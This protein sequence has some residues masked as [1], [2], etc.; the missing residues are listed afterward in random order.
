MSKVAVSLIMK[1]FKQVWQLEYLKSDL[2]E[3]IRCI[4]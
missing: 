3:E 1:N 4:K 2:F